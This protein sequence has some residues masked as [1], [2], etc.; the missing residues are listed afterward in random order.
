MVI[1]IDK[2]V[3]DGLVHVIRQCKISQFSE[4]LARPHVMQEDL[5]SV[6][7]AMAADTEHGREALEWS[8]ALIGDVADEAQ[9]SLVGRV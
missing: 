2:E 1:T 3:Y 7:Q 8:S 4:D 6:Y 5:A 9:L